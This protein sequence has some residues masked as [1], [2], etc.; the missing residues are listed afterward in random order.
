MTD[1]RF[2]R[3][4]RGPIPPGIGSV[5][6]PDNGMCLSAFLV[7]EPPHRDGW[8][9][10]GKLNTKAPWWEIGALDPDR[11]ASLGQLWMLPSSQLMLFESPDEAARRV[12]REQL[13][14]HGLEL[15]GP[16]VFSDPSPRP[17]GPGVDPHW[18]M[19]FVYRGRW[20]SDQPPK[21]SPWTS[22]EFVE[23]ARLARGEIARF[24]GDVLELIGIRPR[25]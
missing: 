21:A 18:D 24:Q 13:D 17:G 3:I 11:L 2:A 20:K 5:E 1:R 7:I 10:L 25:D 9:L 12:L 19:H 4:R 8:V 16:Q 22:L 6:A 23:V 14:T 15:R